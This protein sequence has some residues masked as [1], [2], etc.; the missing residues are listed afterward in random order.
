MGGVYCEDVD[1]AQTVPADS[2]AVF[3]A[4]PWILDRDL[5]RRLWTKSEEWT[6]VRMEG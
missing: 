3:G 6:N 5:A 4:R 2:T 1:I